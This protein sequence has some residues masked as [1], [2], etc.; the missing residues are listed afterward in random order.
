VNVFYVV[1]IY[2]IFPPGQKQKKNL[3]L[4]RINFSKKFEL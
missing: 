2:F 1:D 3:V 4:S